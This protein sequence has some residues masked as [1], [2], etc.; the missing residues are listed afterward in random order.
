MRTIWVL[1]LANFAFWG[2]IQF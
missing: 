1:S 2:Y